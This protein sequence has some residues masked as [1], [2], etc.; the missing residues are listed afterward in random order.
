MSKETKVD[1]QVLFSFQASIQYWAI[2]GPIFS[3]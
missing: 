3:Q 2:I 1:T